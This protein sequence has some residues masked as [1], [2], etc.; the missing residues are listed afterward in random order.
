MPYAVLE[1]EI[2]MLDEAQQNTVALFVH[3]FLS[4][5]TSAAPAA[6]AS[7]NK[8]QRVSMYGAPKGKVGMSSDFDAPI[9]DFAEYM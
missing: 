5:K 2:E 7:R 3:F 6:A 8:P 4:Q 1:K 9:E